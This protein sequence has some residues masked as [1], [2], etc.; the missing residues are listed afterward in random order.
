[1]QT[2]IGQCVS[3]EVVHTA[4]STRFEALRNSKSRGSESE[5]KSNGSEVVDHVDGVG[6][7]DGIIRVG[8]RGK[9]CKSLATER[10]DVLVL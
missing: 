10:L 8:E 9:T 4:R 1:M 2:Y 6:D 7:G 5:K 3:R